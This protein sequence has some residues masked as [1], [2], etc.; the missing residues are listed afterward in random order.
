MNKRVVVM[1]LIFMCLSLAS[2]KVYAETESGGASVLN[3]PQVVIRGLVNLVTSPLEFLRTP[4]VEQREHKWLWPI[5]FIPR[6]ARNGIYRAASGLND[7]LFYPVVAPFMDE[8]PPLTEQV[9]ISNYIW[10]GGDE[11]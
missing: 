1:S 8:N 3:A 5:T 7:I 2:E 10:Q 9:G 11:Y 4:V 6:A